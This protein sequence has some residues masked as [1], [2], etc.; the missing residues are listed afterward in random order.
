MPTTEIRLADIPAT[1]EITNCLDGP[2]SLMGLITLPAGKPVVA[3][4]GKLSPERRMALYNTIRRAVGA[5]S[6]KADVDPDIRRPAV[7]RESR[8][9]ELLGTGIPAATGTVEPP[10]GDTKPE[11]EGKPEAPKGEQAPF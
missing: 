1:L 8:D 6:V 11:L 2:L 3:E 4:L 7:T 5:G 10:E 9:A